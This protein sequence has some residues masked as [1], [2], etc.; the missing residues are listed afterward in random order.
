MDALRKLYEPNACAL[1][2][3]LRVSL[4][5]WLPPAAV[6]PRKTDAWTVMQGLRSPEAL[7]SRLTRHVSQQS[8]AVNLDSHDEEV[9]EK[10][11]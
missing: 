4:P 5:Q 3:Y 7:A 2:D 1:A 10:A 8:T 11:L 9:P 6:E